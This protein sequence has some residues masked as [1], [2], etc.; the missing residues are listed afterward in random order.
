MVRNT[1]ENLGRSRGAQEL[2]KE[3]EAEKRVSAEKRLHIWKGGCGE[4]RSRQLSPGVS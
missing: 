1:K 4:Q 2:T 3:Q